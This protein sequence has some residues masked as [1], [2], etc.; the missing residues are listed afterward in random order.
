MFADFILPFLNDLLQFIQLGR[1]YPFVH[2]QLDRWF[3]PKLGLAI[4]RNHM[5]MQAR[6][7]TREK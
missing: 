1:A 5:H 3:Q 6:L 2:G 4:R 7:L